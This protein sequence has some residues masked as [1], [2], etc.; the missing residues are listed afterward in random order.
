V[1]CLPLLLG[2]ECLAETHLRVVSVMVSLAVSV[3]AQLSSRLTLSGTCAYEIVN[4]N[5]SYPQGLA[6]ENESEHVKVVED[7]S[8]F[9]RSA[10]ENVLPKIL[11]S[12]G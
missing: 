11:R 12:K 3:D 1:P 4:G 6:R 7:G 10:Y 9:E 2:V 5:A 8:D